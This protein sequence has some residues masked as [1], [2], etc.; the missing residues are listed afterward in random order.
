[1]LLLAE[2]RARGLCEAALSGVGLPPDEVAICADAIVFASLRGLDSH[3]I[4]SILPGICRSVTAGR[5]DP[6]ARIQQIGPRVLKGNGAAGPVIGA[7]TMQL[8][9]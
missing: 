8:A 4:V 1:M 7:R 9:M 5:I 3:G 6:G 2:S